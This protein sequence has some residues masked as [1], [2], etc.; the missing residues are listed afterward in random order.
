MTR[1][2]SSVAASRERYGA[3][4]GAGRACFEYRRVAFILLG[5]HARRSSTPTYRVHRHAHGNNV[6]NGCV[7]GLRLKS[8]VESE[9]H[10]SKLTRRDAS[11]SGS[12]WGLKRVVYECVEQG[13]T[14]ALHAGGRVPPARCIVYARCGRATPIRCTAQPCDDLQRARPPATGSGR[15]AD[16]S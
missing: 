10:N 1:C 4:D 5:S 14:G 11:L 3:E 8:E 6:G 12:G 16:L 7:F 9:P 2:A 13:M 15:H